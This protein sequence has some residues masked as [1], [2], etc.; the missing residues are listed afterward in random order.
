MII[1]ILVLLLLLPWP[2]IVMMSPMLIAAPAAVDRRSNLLMV[3]AMALYPFFFALL[4]YAAQRPFFGISANTCLAISALCCGILFVLYG[5]PRMLWNNFRGIANEG[6]FATRRAVY[7]NGKRIAKAQPASFRQPVKMFSPYA[8]DAE[9]VFFKTT[10]LAGA[11]AGSFIDLGDDFAKDAT[12]VFFRG[13]VLLLDTESKRAADASSFARVPRLKVPGEQEID[14]FAR[15]FFRDSTGLY[16]LKRWQRDQIVKL[17]VADA[18]SFIVLSGGYAKDKQQ[19]YQL[20]E[21]AYQISVVAG[22]D[23][24]SFRPD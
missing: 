21:R 20:D 3:S 23:P 9:R 24:A 17:E 15:D 10:V 6:Y 11:D 12:T 22:A 8:R 16:W 1:N 18:Q 2:L 13:K 14:A 7:L 4:F 5:L 19:V